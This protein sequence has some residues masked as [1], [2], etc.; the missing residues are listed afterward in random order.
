MK[1]SDKRSNSRPGLGIL[2]L[3]LSRP[4]RSN[5]P[6]GL[7][8]LDFNL[9]RPKRPTRAQVSDKGFSLSRPKRSQQTMALPFGLIFSIILI[10]VFIVIA[11]IAVNHFLDI[12]KC[13]QIGGFYDS[14]QEAVD[15]AWTSQSSDFEFEIELSG[16]EKICFANLSE[17]PT[18]SEEYEQIKNYEVYEANV[19]LI[20]AEKTC[21]MPYKNIKHLDLVKII[22]ERNPYCVEVDLGLKIKKDFYD[23]LVRVE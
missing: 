7:S 4:K 9:S 8:P 23:K 18:N 13:A 14:L 1:R 12:G 15:E 6:S 22:E 21:N 10:V 17:A 11:F 20:P 5:S 19:F 16:I 2:S 3:N